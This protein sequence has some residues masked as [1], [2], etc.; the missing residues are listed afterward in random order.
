MGTAVRSHPGCSAAA[1][2]NV[3]VAD[4]RRTEG[5]ASRDDQGRSRGGRITEVVRRWA[6]PSLWDEE[7]SQSDLPAP[8]LTPRQAQ[9]LLPELPNPEEVTDA[10]P[11][12]R[13]AGARWLV[14]AAVTGYILLFGLWTTRHHDGLGTQ[15]FDTGIYDQGLW[16][17]SRFERPFV[18]VM[19]RNL[20]GD[21]T[22]FILLPL[23]PVYWLI[24]SVKVLLWA[25][26]AALGA[27]A[28]PTFLLAREK[29]R[30]EMLA[31]MLAIAYLLQPVLGWTNL[32]HFHPDVFEVPLVLFALLFMTRER[33]IPFLV[34]V[35]LLLLVKEDALLLAFPLG[36]YV[37][38]KHDRRVGIATCVGSL[39]YAAAALWWILPALNGVGT[40]NSWRVPFGGPSGLLRTAITHPGRVISHMTTPD[41]IWYV[42]QLFAP[43]GLL[44]AA[45]PRVLLIGAPALGSNLLSTFLYQHDIQFHYSTLIFPVIV[46][47]SI[48]GIARWPS[49]ADRKRLVW[50][51]L[52]AAVVTAHLWGPTPLG[53]HEATFADP[54]APIVRHFRDAARQVPDDAVV[55][56]HYAW[57]PQIDHREE[58]YMFP[59]PWKANYWGTFKQEG[60]RLPLADRVQYILVPTQLDAELTKVLDPIRAEFDVAYDAGGVTLLRRKG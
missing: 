59:N 27:G 30:N 26:A 6:G 53:R 58:V 60:Q 15:A 56:V 45:A 48:Y 13:S 5:S 7:F 49:A 57:L 37:A 10:R 34:C 50:A 46:A 20:F 24:P 51:V 17:L 1:G 25:Q 16:L 12:E 23:V 9:T 8:E 14:A 40:L 4:T 36:I 21:H 29:L 2:Q 47:A 11:V 43:L 31:A 3:L 22:S 28:V 35:G 33:W 38:I 39:L 42:W 32:E 52:G 54:D 19:G 18:T 55:S 41:K 44:A